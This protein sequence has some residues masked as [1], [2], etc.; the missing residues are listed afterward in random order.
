LSGKY[1]QAENLP[2]EHVLNPDLSASAAAFGFKLLH[3]S[4]RPARIRVTDSQA[5]RIDFDSF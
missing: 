5:R 1:P 3:S 2:P 4:S